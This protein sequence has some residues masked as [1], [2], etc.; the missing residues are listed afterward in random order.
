MPRL[1]TGS[2]K[3]YTHNTGLSCCFRQWRAESHCNKWHGYA[4]Q[5]EV[6]F[7]GIPDNKNWIVDFGGLKTFKAFLEDLFDHTMIVA[8]DDPELEFYQQAETKGLCNLRILPATGCE[9][10]SKL[11]Y[12]WLTRWVRNEEAFLR[13]D[14][15]VAEVVVR[16][17]AGNSGYTRLSDVR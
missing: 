17:H 16:E 1:I 2:S 12:V 4:L 11:I 10:F 7:E 6:K 14:V 3:T 15:V 13:R 5:V 8:A 9:A